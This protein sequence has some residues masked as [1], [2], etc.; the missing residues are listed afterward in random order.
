METS[1]NERLDIAREPVADMQPDNFW[2]GTVKE[3][4][5]AKIVV[6]GNEYEAV[7]TRVIPDFSVSP[8]VQPDIVHMPAFRERRRQ[9]VCK[10][11][12]QVLVE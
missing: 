7:L 12:A 11:R 2:R 1:K 3:A 6:F 5:L 9:A 4:Q 10:A 8:T